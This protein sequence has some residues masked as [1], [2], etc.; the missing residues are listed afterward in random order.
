MFCR[1]CEEGYESVTT[2]VYRKT[3]TYGKNTLFTEFRLKG[4]CTLPSH[5][6]PQ[7]QTGY[8]VSGSLR[9]TIGDETFD[10]GPGDS[11]NIPGNVPHGATVLKDS[12][13]IEVFSPIR[14]D[15]LPRGRK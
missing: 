8:L 6:H 13:A 4:N 12:V 3:L 10:V 15:Y 7:E 9:L 1:S 2:G 5:S 14:E 11:W